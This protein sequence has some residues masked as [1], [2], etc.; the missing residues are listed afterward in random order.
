[1]AEEIEKEFK[2]LVTKEEF[3]LLLQTFH[4]SNHD[5]FTQ[6]NHYFDT[7]D[8]SLKEKAASLRIRELPD[9]YELTLK[10]KTIEDA[11]ETNQ[12][13]DQKEA[14]LLLN[15]SICPA[16]E[17]QE[18]LVKLGIHLPDL[19]HFGSLTTHR[20]ELEYKEGLLVFDHSYYLNQEDFELEYEVTDWKLGKTF[21]A[22][23]LNRLNIQPQ[24][25]DTKVGRLYR[26][27]QAIMKQSNKE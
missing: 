18:A 2:N 11:I 7:H 17:V 26:A 27:K 19:T 23:L 22:D 16:G 5:F 12:I 6:K 25:T 4:I 20:A 8:F 1:M 10:K 21:F 9:C 15:D 24:S 3:T 13:I 14:N